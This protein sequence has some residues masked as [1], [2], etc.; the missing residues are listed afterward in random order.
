MALDADYTLAPIGDFT[1]FIGASWRYIG[2][3][4][5]AFDPARGQ[6]RLPSYSTFDARVGVERENWSLELYGK[7][8]TDEEGVTNLGSSTSQAPL[9]ADPRAGP[10]ISVIRPRVFG[11]V[12]TGK[13]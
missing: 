13:L 9:D 5:S 3:R 10:A 1:P 7:N 6:T 11:I 4:D 8:L 12:L 2:D